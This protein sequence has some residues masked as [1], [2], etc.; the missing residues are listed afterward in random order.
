MQLSQC[1]C[2]LRPTTLPEWEIEMRRRPAFDCVWRNNS[3]DA[4][5]LMHTEAGR[6]AKLTA[7]NMG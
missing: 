4:S 1:K 3:T 6:E 2:F 7:W 5:N